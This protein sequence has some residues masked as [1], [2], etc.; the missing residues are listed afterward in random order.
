MYPAT[1][2]LI[3]LYLSMFLFVGCASNSD[4]E[5]HEREAT[6]KLSDSESSEYPDFITDATRPTY[7]PR[8]LANNVVYPEEAIEKDMEGKV[9]MMVYLEKDGSIKKVEVLQSDN[10]IFEE[11]AIEAVRKTSFSPAIRD[12]LGIK[13]KIPV[14]VRFKLN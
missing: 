3:L 1:T 5:K 9:T 2:I 11:A 12:G 6:E 13:F 10:P 8:E 4:R 7:S 14:S